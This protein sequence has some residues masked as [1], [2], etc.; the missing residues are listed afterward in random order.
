MTGVQTCALPISSARLLAADLRTCRAAAALAGRVDELGLA[1]VVDAI[2]LTGALA[3][4][5]SAARLGSGLSAAADA[6]GANAAPLRA[7]V[8]SQVSRHTGRGGIANCMGKGL[9][10]RGWNCRP[11]PLLARVYTLALGVWGCG[12]GDAM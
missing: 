10:V 9:T 2:G 11:R 3:R 1:V 4:V 12:C 7:T 8:N 5:D 6:L